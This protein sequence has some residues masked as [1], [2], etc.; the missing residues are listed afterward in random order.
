MFSSAVLLAIYLVLVFFSYSAS[1]LATTALSA[2]MPLCSLPLIGSSIPLCEL[3]IQRQPR[4]PE[5]IDL[6]TRFEDIME[7]SATSANLALDMKQSE[8]AVRDLNTLVRFW[9]PH[10]TLL[11]LTYFQV[12]VSSLPSKE[13]LSSSLDEFVSSAKETGR[14]LAKLGSGVGGAVDA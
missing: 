5:L 14:K 11:N 6:Q 12:K 1:Y 4:Y 3:P 2:L 13:I 9:F 10:V 7:S 8:V